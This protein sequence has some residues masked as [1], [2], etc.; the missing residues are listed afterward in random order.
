M[1]LPVRAEDFTTHEQRTK[2]EDF[3][4]SLGFGASLFL[5]A[6]VVTWKPRKIALDI[7]CYGDVRAWHE[8]FSARKE[9]ARAIRVANN[10]L[11]WSRG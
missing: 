3:Q 1:N 4:E 7:H 11:K 6:P 10:D 8:L 5:Q 9:I 2:L